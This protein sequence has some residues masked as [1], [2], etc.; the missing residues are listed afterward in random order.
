MYAQTFTNRVSDET[1]MEITKLEPT[2]IEGRSMVRPKGTKFDCEKGEFS[3]P[4]SEWENFAW[5]PE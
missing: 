5:I 2:R 3:E 4:R 1:A